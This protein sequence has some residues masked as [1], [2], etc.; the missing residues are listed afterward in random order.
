MGYTISKYTCTRF[1]I[2]WSQEMANARHELRSGPSSSNSPGATK[3]E[4]TEAQGSPTM[5]VLGVPSAW[6]EL[7]EADEADALP[8]A[9]TRPMGSCSP[10]SLIGG[11]LRE[12][13]LVPALTPR[14]LAGRSKVQGTSKS[15]QFWQRP[16][17]SSLLLHL[18]L[19]LL[20]K[21]PK[22]HRRGRSVPK[23]EF[24]DTSIRKVGRVEH[25]FIHGG[26]GYNDLQALETRW[27]FR[28]SGDIHSCA[29]PPGK[30]ITSFL[31]RIR[32]VSARIRGHDA[33]RFYVNGE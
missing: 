22:R 12:F 26:E 23:L 32:S 8:G 6:T 16:R 21:S 13:T 14:R 31:S 11:V 33:G 7:R 20:Q 9:P 30:S 1:R 4:L 19:R 27:S 3:R 18:M 24:F 5:E 25:E 15:E 29:V 2:C 10:V 17:L 28:G